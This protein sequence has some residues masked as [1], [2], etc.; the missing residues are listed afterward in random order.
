MPRNP[1]VRKLAS[2]L[3]ARLRAWF[4]RLNGALRLTTVG[5]VRFRT[6]PVV[7]KPPIGVRLFR[8]MNIL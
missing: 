5:L 1:P 7:L 6:P 3:I 8:R 2:R 4:I